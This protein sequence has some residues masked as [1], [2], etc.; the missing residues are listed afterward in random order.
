MCLWLCISIYIV[1]NRYVGVHICANIILIQSTNLIVHLSCSFVNINEIDFLQESFHATVRLLL[2]ILKEKVSN[3]SIKHN[4]I[5][6]NVGI[7]AHLGHGSR[8]F[9]DPHEHTSGFETHPCL[10]CTSRTA[11][12]V[13]S[14]LTDLT[15]TS[16]ITC[17]ARDTP[18]SAI[19]KP[20][21]I[22]S[23]ECSSTTSHIITVFFRHNHHV[24]CAERVFTERVRLRKFIVT[25]SGN[26]TEI[27][28]VVC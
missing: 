17:F 20:Y 7:V 6:R 21:I 27:L 3:I 18:I 10:V 4:A 12:D 23:R 25:I 24:P 5:T 11:T 22:S 1:A 8:H 16:I 13:Q 19:I 26:Q 28:V 2:V 14:V 9:R 15:I